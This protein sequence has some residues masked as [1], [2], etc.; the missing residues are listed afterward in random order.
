MIFTSD[1]FG[2]LGRFALISMV[3]IVPWL[4]GAELP[5]EQL[6]IVSPMLLVLSCLLLAHR[7]LSSLSRSAWAVV[8]WLVG[9]L[10]YS[11]LFLMP[12]PMSWVAWL[13][14]AAAI[15]QQN[16]A[17]GGSA[18]LTV[19][20]Q[21][22]A[23]ELLKFAGLVTG[24]LLVWAVCKTRQRV[25]QL[26]WAIVVGGTLTAL[27]SQLNYA[28]GGD[29]EVVAAIPPWDFSWQEG[30]RGTFS[31]KNQYALYMVI[32]VCLALGLTADAALAR[33]QRNRAVMAGSVASLIMLLTLLNTSSRGALLALLLAAGLCIL[34]LLARQRSLWT[35]IVQ[36]KWLAGGAVLLILAGAGFTQTSIYERFSSQAMA[37]NGRTLLRQTATE[38]WLQSPWLGT[39]PGTYPLVQHQ[40]KPL[41]LGN[42]QMSK[43][44]HN[45]Y[46]ET[47]ASQGLIGFFLLA[48]PLVLLLHRCFK[49]SVLPQHNGLLLG[50]QTATLAYLIQAS[51]DVNIGVLV[52][53][54][55][56]ILLLAMA[57]QLSPHGRRRTE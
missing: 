13:N 45:D 38:A 16:L 1:P 27:Y 53:P 8:I 47:L 6:F 29:Y 15:W 42:S 35:V 41:E 21:A 51:F 43:R 3:L 57:W 28:T 20:W 32:C 14:P 25:V 22:S 56:F 24:L 5:F 34:L 2:A 48:V 44:A 31:Y 50:I 39:G 26:A 36:P 30:I 54:M 7:P 40:Y 18:H 33:P 11:A 46:L 19:G 52:L 23:L 10:L 4:H 37:D 12:V 49:V 9:W 55:L 17:P